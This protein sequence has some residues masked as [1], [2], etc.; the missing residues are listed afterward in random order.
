[1]MPMTSINGKTGLLTVEPCPGDVNLT[2]SLKFQGQIFVIA[3][4]GDHGNNLPCTLVMLCGFVI[5]N[6]LGLGACPFLVFT[7]RLH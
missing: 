1:M 6:A 3:P 7:L 2:G 5:I 4:I